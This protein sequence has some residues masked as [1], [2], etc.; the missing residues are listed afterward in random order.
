MLACERYERGE[1][2][3]ILI[4]KGWTKTKIYIYIYLAFEMNMSI[5]E[6]IGRIS[7]RSSC[8]SRPTIRI[9][10]ITGSSVEEETRIPSRLWQDRL[11]A[12]HNHN[13]TALHLWTCGSG[14]QPRAR[15]A[16]FSSSMAYKAAAR[17]HR[18]GVTLRTCRW[19]FPFSLAVLVYLLQDTTA[20]PVACTYSSTREC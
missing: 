17:C 3:G 4:P 9:G 13:L 1:C 10:Q 14:D 12:S 15:R 5:E 2:R 16:D 8:Y 11:T 20:Q 18:Y 7:V 19:Y 6:Q